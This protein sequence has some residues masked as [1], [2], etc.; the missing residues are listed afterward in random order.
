MPSN[1]SDQNG[2]KFHSVWD[3]S[4]RIFHWVNVLCIIG[5]VAVGTVILN[6]KL[7]GVS[8]DGK[9]LLKEVH[10][11]IGY[12]FALN[13]S[14]R[15]IWGF[16]GNKYSRWSS[17]LPFT[18]GYSS[19]LKEFIAAEKTTNPK[20]YL[21]HNPLARLMVS[22]LFILLTTQAITGLVLA[23]TDVYMPPFGN[24]I[25]EWVAEKD[26]NGNP[27]A[28]KAGSKEGVNKEAYAEMRSFRKPYIQVHY[29]AFYILL[30][31]IFIH[32]AFVIFTEVKDKNG[33]ISAMFT[34]NKI[35]SKKPED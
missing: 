25:A 20:Q 2:L 29:F 8:G 14:W 28:I 6:G 13:L 10:V 30:A 35:T 16:I 15:I 7:L 3:R 17:I 26:Q 32:I 11:Y 34:G 1:S 22:L 21:G 27:V 12:L 5:L 23:G 24:N 18:A 9:I 31:A 19:A 4:T 33:L